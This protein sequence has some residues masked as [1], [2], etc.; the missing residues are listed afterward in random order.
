ME[1]SNPCLIEQQLSN[2]KASA[3]SATE[4][5]LLF[6]LLKKTLSNLINNPFEEKHRVICKDSDIFMNGLLKAHEVQDILKILGFH[7]ENEKYI[8]HISDENLMKAESCLNLLDIF[9]SCN[10]LSSP[11]SE[12]SDEEVQEEFDNEIAS[13]KARSLPDLWTEK[14]EDNAEERA[15]NA[16]KKLILSRH[17]KK[18]ENKERVFSLRSPAASSS[19]KG[20]PSITFNANGYFHQCCNSK[21][22]K[23]DKSAISDFF[24]KQ[25]S[26]SKRWSVSGTNKVI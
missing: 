2:I 4:I 5:D 6:R 12:L 9:R 17:L 26:R 8:H 24:H 3:L 13:K 22:Q 10:E 19:Q 7:E 18:E 21:T 20:S 14:R 23:K 25:D 15:N 11:G 16:V 1:T